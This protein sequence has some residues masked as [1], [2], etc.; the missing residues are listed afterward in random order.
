MTLILANLQIHAEHKE[1]NRACVVIRDD[2]IIAIETD[3]KT[4]L[5]KFQPAEVIEFPESYHLVPGFI[6]LHTHGAN[7]SDV[8]DATQDALINICKTLAREGTTGF[9]ATTM[10]ASSEAIEKALANVREVMQISQNVGASILGVHLEGPFIS[11]KKIGAQCANEILSPTVASIQR[12]QKVS[13][14]AIKLLTLAPELENSREVIR[15]LKQNNI[16]ASMGHTHASYAESMIAIEEGCSHATHLFNAMRG[17]HQREPG[18]VT[19]AL[20]SEKVIAE[21][22]VDGV[23][24]HP[25]IV[26]LAFKLKGKDKIVLIT[27][28]MRAKCLHDGV[29]EL[30]GQSVVV[31]NKVA[32]LE[33]GTLA[34]SV[35]TMN[36]ALQNVLAFTGCSLADAIKMA[37]ENP[38][39]E[40][41]IFSKKGSI[42]LNKDADLV[43]L[44]DKL[45][46]VLTLC[47]GNIVYEAGPNQLCTNKASPAL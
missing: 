43:V 29:Y 14:N 33:D 45:K 13:G 47:G 20:L 15:Y 8:M 22:I 5:T 19:A 7:G 31:K 38:A 25:A 9:L 4:T 11:A 1:L 35:L 28:A 40:L 16:I 2:K 6:D 46:V 27:D 23:H 41:G 3:L 18:I 12:W 36:S 30:G 42:A 21:L 34:G 26:E 10:T 39:R 17:I 37:A 32:S 44:D 24:L